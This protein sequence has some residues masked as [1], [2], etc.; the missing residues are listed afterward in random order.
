MSIN[1]YTIKSD[2]LM[3]HMN[4]IL[5]ILLKFK[6]KIHFCSNVANEYWV[7]SMKKDDEN[8]TK[9]ITSNEQWIYLR[10]KQELKK[11]SFIY[12]QFS[13]LMFES[14][15]SN[16]VN[17]IRMFTIIDDHD[18]TIFVVFMNDHDVSTTNFDNLFDF[19]HKKYFLKCVFEFV[20]LSNHKIHLLFD[21]V[22][23][24]K[25]E[26]N[27]KKLRSTRKHKKKI[28]EWFIS[29]NREKLNA[30]L[31]LTLFL[32]IFISSKAK[33]ILEMK[34]FYMKLISNKS[35][36]KKKHDAEIEHCDLNLIKSIRIYRI[37]RFTI[38]RKYVKKSI[39]DWEEN[40]QK[41]FE[42]VKSTIANNAMIEINQNFQFHLI[43]DASETEL[44]ECLFQLNEMKSK[45]EIIFKWLFNEKNN[46]F[47]SFKLVDAKTRYFNIEKKCYIIVKCLTEIKWLMMRNKHSIMIYIDHKTSKFIFATKQ[48]E[49][50]RI[51]IWL[52]M[53][54][55]YDLQLF[56]RFN[57]NQ[58]LRIIDELSKI[59]TRLMTI[60]DAS[61]SKKMS[62]LVIQMKKK[63]KEINNSKI[64]QRTDFLNYLTE[65]NLKKYKS[66]F[67]YHQLIEYLIKNEKIIIEMKLFKN[68]KRILKHLTKNY[69]LFFSSE[70]KHLKY[71]ERNEAFNICII[72]KKVKS[73][74]KTTHENHDHFATILTLNFLIER[75]YWFTRIKNVKKWCKSCHVCQAR[76]TKSIRN[77][78][79]LIKKFNSM[80]MLEMNWLKSI[81][82][83]CS[84]IEVKFILLVIDYFTRFL[85]A[86]TY[87]YHEIFEMIDMLRDVIISIFEWMNNLYSNNDS[88]FVNHNVRIVLE[89]HEMSHF[90][91]SISHSFSIDLLKRAMQT[92][93]SMLSK[94]CIERETVNS[95]FLMLRN[96]V[97]ILNTN[98]IKIHS[99]NSTQLMLKFESQFRHYDITSLSIF[100]IIDESFSKHQYQLF[101]ILKDEQRLLEKEVAS[102]IHNY[103]QQRE[104]K[105]KI[106]KKDDLIMIRNHAVNNQKNKKFEF[107]WLKSRF[108]IKWIKNDKSE[109]IRELHEVDEIKKYHFD[110]MIFYYDKQNLKEIF[111]K[112]LF[113]IYQF[114]FKI[115]IL[116][117]QRVLIL[118]FVN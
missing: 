63:L 67:M 22:K 21:E 105:Q 81:I 65:K 41:A 68:R 75:I 8:K 46:M 30:F 95:W 93:L 85:W 38:Q 49:K 13:D 72:E 43:N 80:I 4:E 69:K 5:I 26:E 79:L 97:L 25:F 6:F 92:L 57:R 44:N 104:R 51:T 73:Y 47:L 23:L 109:W 98:Y 15:S 7:I 32:R 58:H 35:K 108:L 3:H 55:E 87:R 76:L 78:S 56:H 27:A 91:D 106:S 116:S 36:S 103:E 99:Y 117:K 31:W 52:N 113:S 96:Y 54:K 107:R 62:M 39:F 110:D 66:F 88:H 90:T 82:S 111:S 9:F 118:S 24:L 10:M 100:S 83:T 1:K 33:L 71:I 84:I 29:K 61:L 101:T 19:L 16:E 37:K 50:K 94:K 86:K 45:T 17:I 77:E 40:Q 12:A 18:D 112:E 70:I 74:L 34:K 115:I 114:D 48:I 28:R 64:R 11:S 59:S 102:Y 2:Y 42:A 14:F 60:N 53:L 20:Y 89:E